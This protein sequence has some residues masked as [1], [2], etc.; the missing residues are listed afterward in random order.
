MYSTAFGFGGELKEYGTALDPRQLLA[1]DPVPFGLAP[2]VTNERSLDA[3]VKYASDFMNKAVK[4][5]M[6]GGVKMRWPGKA[7]DA[8]I[9]LSE[10]GDC[11]SL[12]YTPATK[13]LT[14]RPAKRQHT[15][16]LSPPP[17]LPLYNNAIF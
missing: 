4:P 11:I 14:A 2:K 17:P 10:A 16:A 5:V 1:G 13:V 15:D 3:A 9:H 6:V 8:F 12:R 7:Q